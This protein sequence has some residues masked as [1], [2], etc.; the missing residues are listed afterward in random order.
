MDHATGVVIGETA[1]VGDNVSLLHRVTLG[2]SGTGRDKR[3]PTIG[4]AQ[5]APLCGRELEVGSSWLI[6][7]RAHVQR[8]HS[9][10]A[11]AFGVVYGCPPLLI[12]T[13]V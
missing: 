7:D 1:V 12:W 8:L 9:A 10:G 4:A 13:L 3:H 2:G 5:T 6:L 11:P